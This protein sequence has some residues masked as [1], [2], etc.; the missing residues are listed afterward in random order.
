MMELLIVIAVL[1]ILAV[2]GLD[3]FFFSMAKGRDAQRKAEL[4]AVVK[5]LETYQNDFNRYP[6][7]ESGLIMGCGDG[8]SECVW[9][10]VFKA[11]LRGAEQVYMPVLPVE[12]TQGG[13]YYYVSDGQG[14]ALYATLEN[15]HDKAYQAATYNVEGASC[16]SNSC[17]YKIT[18]AGVVFP[19]G[20]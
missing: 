12:P 17:Y 4:S 2:V 10:E 1:G 16:G 5:A 8:T 14:F 6:L 15:P 18:E 13:S 9:G 20:E 3:S 11:T 19:D 7:G